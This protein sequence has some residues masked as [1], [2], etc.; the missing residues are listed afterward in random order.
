MRDFFTCRALRFVFSVLCLTILILLCNEIAIADQP[1]QTLRFNYD[2]NGNIVSRTDAAGVLTS[3]VYDPMDRFIAIKYPDKTSVKY[4]YDALGRVIRMTDHLGITDYEYDIHDRL[5]SV[6]D[7]NNNRLRYEYDSNDLI[8]GMTYPDGTKV[9]YTYDPDSRLKTVRIPSGTVKYKYDRGGR[10]AERTLPNGIRTRYSYDKV[11]RL[12]AI[13]HREPNGK[14]ILGFEY[15]L[16]KLGNLS[17]TVKQQNGSKLT[18]CYS[19][20]HMSRLVEAVSHDD[21]VTRYKYDDLGN[22]IQVRDSN[23]G[24]TAYEY[25]NRGYLIGAKTG[26]EITRYR[27]DANGNLTESGLQ[28]GRMLSY[29]WNYEDRLTKFVDAKKVVELSYDGNGILL[30]KTVNSKTTQYINDISIGMPLVVGE[31]SDT[32]KPYYH[33]LEPLGYREKPGQARYF[34]GD[35]LGSVAGLTDS[36]GNLVDSYSYDPFG[37]PLNG[38]PPRNTQIAGLCYDGDTKL[39]AGQ[40]SP[41]I[42]RSIQDLGRLAG[43]AYPILK[44]AAGWSAKGKGLLETAFYPSGYRRAGESWIGQSKQLELFSPS[45]ISKRPD[46]FKR[47]RA[48]HRSMD[49]H[50]IGPL[51]DKINDGFD[52]MEA[53]KG[54]WTAGKSLQARMPRTAGVPVRTWRGYEVGCRTIMGGR[55]CGNC[56]SFCPNRLTDSHYRNGSAIELRSWDMPG[57][58][59]GPRGSLRL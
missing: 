13:Y 11:G 52:V 18:V 35:G 57:Y 9:S 17:Q 25:D 24:K 51:L 30:K 19:Y 36:K 15:E 1:L 43:K 37:Q 29:E 20:D 10:V 53:A 31:V 26:T 2:V 8:T 34:L 27:Y 5:I 41:D 16:D 3:Y 23:R 39:C 21:S 32:F 44:D 47:L 58:S 50:R 56:S 6:K 49:K 33:G 40:Y 46:N 14:P 7:P 54:G 45:I 4:E 38:V 48:F 12:K 59:Q 28:S 42:G 22:R 55:D